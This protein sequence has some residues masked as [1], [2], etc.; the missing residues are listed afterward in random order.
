MKQPELPCQN[1]TQIFSCFSSNLSECCP[2][3]LSGSPCLCVEVQG[4]TYSLPFPFL[5]LLLV[6]L[7]LPPF[8][9]TT[10]ASSLYLKYPRHTSG[11]FLCLFP[12]AENALLP[13][14]RQWHLSFFFSQ[15][16]SDGIFSQSPFPQCLKFLC[17]APTLSGYPPVSYFSLALVTLTYYMFYLLN[18]CIV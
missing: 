10:P 12:S 13:D 6:T 8:S 16:Y 7:P 18:L 14:E 15:F 9:P 3:T 17:S 4:P 5:N 1:I 11:L 2:L